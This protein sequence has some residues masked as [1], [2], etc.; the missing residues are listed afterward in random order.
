[1]TTE[2]KCVKLKSGDKIP[3][4]NE[5]PDLGRAEFTFDL[6]YRRGYLRKVLIFRRQ[7]ENVTEYYEVDTDYKP[8]DFSITH[9]SHK[10]TE[11]PDIWRGRWCKE[12][13]AM[14]LEVYAPPGTN[15]LTIDLGSN[16]CFRFEKEQVTK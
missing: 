5:T 4:V 3:F 9:W 6:I 1:M 16:V 2:F 10:G 14:M 15:I 7:Q 11:H 8:L 13:N 12:H